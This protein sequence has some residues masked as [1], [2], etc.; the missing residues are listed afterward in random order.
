MSADTVVAEA[1]PIAKC[2]EVTDGYYRWTD[3]VWHWAREFEPYE[4]RND[5]ST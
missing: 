3:V 4:V 2:H 5:A 1:P